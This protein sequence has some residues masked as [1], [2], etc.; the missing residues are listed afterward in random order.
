MQPDYVQTGLVP[1]WPDYIEI[2]DKE[3]I[4]GLTRACQLARHVLLLA[5]H[6]LKVSILLHAL[7]LFSCRQKQHEDNNLCLSGWY[8]NRRNRLHRAQRD[9][10]AQCIPVPS[11]IRGFPQISLYICEQRGLSW[12]T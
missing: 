10:Q 3:Q 4:E 7:F 11:Q 6:S 12:H 5:G 2:K 1:E 8:E 9:N